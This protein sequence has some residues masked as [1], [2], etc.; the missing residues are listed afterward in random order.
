MC[1][2]VHVGLRRYDRLCKDPEK[3]CLHFSGDE[4]E[5]SEEHNHYSFVNG[6]LKDSDGVT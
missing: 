6:V 2:H 4:Y 1:G 3:V 5:G